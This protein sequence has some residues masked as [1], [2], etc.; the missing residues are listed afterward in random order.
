MEMRSETTVNELMEQGWLNRRGRNA[1]KRNGMNDLKSI[2]RYYQKH[3]GF[4]ALQ[5][6]EHVTNQSLLTLCQAAKPLM[7]EDEIGAANNRHFSAHSFATW[8]SLIPIYYALTTVEKQTAEDAFAELAQSLP[9]VVRRNLFDIS[10]STSLAGI[11]SAME[12]YDQDFAD[13]FSVRS[14]TSVELSR[15]FPQ[16]AKALSEKELRLF[17]EKQKIIRFANQ[18]QGLLNSGG[19]SIPSFL[20]QQYNTLGNGKFP[21]FT[22][23]DLAVINIAFLHSTQSQVLLLSDLIYNRQPALPIDEM[24]VKIGISCVRITQILNKEKKQQQVSGCLS[25]VIDLLKQEGLVIPISYRLPDAPFH[26]FEPGLL[27]V[28]VP[29][30]DV[31]AA[32]IISCLNPDYTLIVAY[33]TRKPILLLFK[34]SIVH[35]FDGASFFAKT[36]DLSRQTVRHDHVVD[37]VDLLQ[38]FCKVPLSGEAMDCLYQTVIPLVTKLYNITPDNNKTLHL[39]RTTKKYIWEYVFDFMKEKKRPCTLDEIMNHLPTVGLYTTAVSVRSL[40]L[41]HKNIFTHTGSNMYALCK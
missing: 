32:Q 37:M 1:C 35:Q 31:F 25:V 41:N 14:R 17:I 33:K 40:M 7:A 3:R 26:I 27:P 30:T 6:I 39:T 10:R 20:L 11:V 5:S 2:Y 24:A 38:S 23:L 34:K 29:F 13:L 18:I 28:H 12:V 4:M 19:K 22:F 21:L 9:K 16:V 36:E 15:F 8:V